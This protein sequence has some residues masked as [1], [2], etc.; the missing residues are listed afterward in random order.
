LQRA[1]PRVHFFREL[2]LAGLLTLA[3]TAAVGEQSLTDQVRERLRNRIEASAQSDSME[4]VDELIHAS[5]VLPTFYERRGYRPAWLDDRGPT[6]QAD[7]L[8]AALRDADREG[9]NPLDYHAARIDTTLAM[10]R[11]HEARGDPPE[12]G[13]MTDLELLLTDAFL[14]YGAH[15]LAGRVDQERLDAEWRA[16]RREADLAQ[17]LE[18]A[19]D[20]TGVRPALSALLPSDPGYVSLRAALQRYRAAAADTCPLVPEGPKMERGDSGERV[21]ALRDRLRAL[22]GLP[23]GSEGARDTFDEELEAAVKQFQQRHG[24]DVD[25]VV[26]R[27][28]L[29]ELNVRQSARVRQIA[30]NME[31]WRWLPLALGS[32]HIII[33]IAD[34]SLAAVESGQAVMSMKVVVGRPYRRTPVF[35]ELMTYLVLNPSWEVAPTIAIE[36]IVPA[37]RKD[38]EYLA[39]QDMR[40]LEGWGAEEREVDPKT[41]DW[42]RVTNRTLR[43]RFRQHPGSGNP[44]GSIKFMFPNKFHIYLHDTPSRQIFAKAE[45]SFSSGCI[46]VERAVDL[47]EYVLRGHRRWTRRRLTAALAGGVEQTVLLPEPIP[48]HLLYWT[49]WVDDHGTL[50][51]RTDIYGRDNL[52]DVALSEPPPGAQ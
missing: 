5:V 24:L 10:E 19:L 36:D 1:S 38:P 42:S 23:G 14:V 29:G 43:Y 17:V 49:A 31:R 35:S 15:L 51:F 21:R 11:A 12:P 18:S 32:R 20:S 4:A 47:A 33:N 44:L 46:R 22:A 13:R 27:A 50:Q 41:V 37:L 16:Q 8:L 25:G 39:K 6:G 34:F 26:G 3:G 52:L 7:S 48:V 9:L 2:G 30:V 40:L 45:R 28:T